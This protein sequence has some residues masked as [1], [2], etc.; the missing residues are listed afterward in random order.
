MAA[1]IAAARDNYESIVWSGISPAE[2][3]I[4]YSF[5][6]ES[7]G[8]TYSLDPAAGKDLTFI[9][10]TQAEINST[11][12]IFSTLEN[13]LD[14]KFVY[15]PTG[16]GDL[17]FGHKETAEGVGGYFAG[18]GIG[19]GDIILDSFDLGAGG[20]FYEAIPLFGA[21]Q[22][23]IHE[24]GHAL[25]LGH[26]FDGQ[27]GNVADA[28]PFE[29][30]TWYATV[31]SYNGIYVGV[32]DSITSF[33]LM[34]VFALQS[35]YGKSK[36]IADNDY[37]A[38]NGIFVVADY[39]GFDTLD[40]S[41]REYDADDVNILD[42]AAG[43]AYYEAKDGGW[44]INN[45]DYFGAGWGDWHTGS[46]ATGFYNIMIA[47]GTKI[48]RLVGSSV[49][50]IV[51]GAKTSEVIITLAGDDMVVAGAGN[52]KIYGAAGADTLDGG[53]GKDVLKGGIDADI[54][55]IA[56]IKDSTVKAADRIADF[57][58]ADGD[59]IDLSSLDA[60]TR[61]DGDQAFSLIGGK[62]FS[63]E[64]GQLI[65]SNGMLSG[66]TNGNGKADFAIAISGATSL[67]AADFVL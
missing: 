16:D 17:K 44:D 10:F 31:M 51:R 61:V 56:A 36:V 41:R 57:S 63:H 22:T 48:E 43:Y 23:L 35:L 37:Y 12:E 33:M 40:L 62:H 34:D 18:D 53:A 14:I 59:L 25:G 60:N 6:L 28:L 55:A 45:Y 26:S 47:P 42:M 5:P 21:Y 65:F 54:F 49:D 11:K 7:T 9:P 20:T 4:T 58:H 1:K 39:G 52:D 19:K 38:T 29:L 27:P 30:D 64:A 50:D 24:I 3:V 8:F 67:E 66:D 32:P 2:K 46:A 13:M 15:D